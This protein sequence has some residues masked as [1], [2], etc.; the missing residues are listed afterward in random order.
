M[1]LAEAMGPAIRLAENGFAVSEKLARQLEEEKA[2]LEQFPVS[3]RI[4]LND[5]KM[6]KAGD[7]LKQPELAATLK[8]IAKNGAEEFYG[9]ETA[10]MIAADMAKSGGVGTMEELAAYKPRVRV[11]LRAKYE[12]GGHGCGVVTRRAP[13]S[14]G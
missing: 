6:W 10:R 9:G 4:F 5:G 12:S 2:G 11:A 13:R 8:R 3:R 14:G 7:T 1:K